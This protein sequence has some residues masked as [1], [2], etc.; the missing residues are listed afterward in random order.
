MTPGEEFR[1][2]MRAANGTSGNQGD[3]LSEVRMIA[4]CRGEMSAIEHEVAEAHLVGCEQCIAL[5]RNA[6]DFLEP[7]RA[8]EKEV[9]ATE[10]NEAWRSFLQRVQI[11][12]S[13]NAE[14]SEGTLVSVGFQ[15]RRDM[16]TLS[17]LSLA[18]AGSL[19]ISLGA[20]GWQTWRLWREQQSQRQS[21][22]IAAQSETDQ[23]ELERRL[24]QLEQT[25]GDQLKREREQRLAAE[26]ERDRLQA[27]LEAMQQA[28]QDIPVY[29]ARLS[30]ER[31][32]DDDVRLRFTGA[33][34]VARL[35]LIIN[36]PYEF[37]EYA[38]E[39]LD[40]SGKIVQEISGLRPAG[41]DGGLSFRVN[42]ATF[43]AGKYRLRLFGGKTKKQLGE[44]GLSVTVGR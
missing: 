14:A 6:R 1:A 16:R 26:A 21:Q 31:G 25:G 34:N 28:G 38:I 3:H 12:A 10:T 19:L 5:F 13:T 2:Y 35:R 33:T 9:T 24:S 27:R 42:R 36:K 32:T 23:R 39:L 41:D 29:T 17:R 4:Y 22:E 15:G 30:S 37:P 7:A 44:Y 20:L 8:D 40:H 43:S 11:Q 18:L